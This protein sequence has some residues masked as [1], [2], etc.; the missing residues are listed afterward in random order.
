MGKITR[1]SKS[2]K[3]F[4]CS[5]CHST[6]PVGSSYIRGT[7]NFHPDIIRCCDCGL[8]NYEVTTSDYVKRVGRI[9]EDWNEDFMSSEYDSIADELQDISDD[10][11]ENYTNMPENLHE[12][13]TGQLLQE[14]IDMLDEVIQNLRDID[15]DTIKQNAID[16]HDWGDEEPPMSLFEVD[17][18]DEL[19][20][21]FEQMLSEEIDE[22]LSYLEY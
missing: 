6:I 3:E 10:L 22:I 21:E 19:H 18:N 11:T 15:E 16:E 20:S 14:R 7:L 2:R 1:I 4:T 9:V 5:K 17:E 8:K 13:E 12:S